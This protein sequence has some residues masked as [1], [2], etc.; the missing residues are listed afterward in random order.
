MRTPSSYEKRRQERVQANQNRFVNSLGK[1]KRSL[2]P[3]AED[4][5]QETEVERRMN[6]SWPEKEEK[7]SSV[8]RSVRS[9]AKRTRERLAEVSKVV[10]EQ[11]D[12]DRFEDGE[13][14]S[15]STSSSFRG[16][17]EESESGSSGSTSSRRSSEMEREAEGEREG[18]RRAL[19]RST[20]SGTKRTTEK[21]KLV[22]D[23]AETQ[24][25]SVE[26][27][28]SSSSEGDQ[29]EEGRGERKG[30]AG[31]GMKDDSLSKPRGRL[32]SSKKK[33]PTRTKKESAQ[34][35]SDQ[36]QTYCFG[37]FFVRHEQHNTII[38][39]ITRTPSLLCQLLEANAL[40]FFFLQEEHKNEQIA[41]DCS[42][43]R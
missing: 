39:H 27:S 10:Q 24:I 43:K 40:S 21:L 11:N 23:E 36:D 37:K 3:E 42:K 15:K 22:K 18:K 38:T 13:E 35:F 4:A 19:R 12:D 25:I 5:G 32:L 2:F 41:R 26:S 14:E 20:R 34:Q 31:S 28:S 8:R 16:S 7:E 6:K 33:K 30:S 9:G 1:L 29:E 17:S